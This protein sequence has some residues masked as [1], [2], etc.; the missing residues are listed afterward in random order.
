MSRKT[1]AREVIV[2][3]VRV[4]GELGRVPTQEEYLLN[5]G[6]FSEDTLELAF[7][8]WDMGIRA[9]GLT[10]S[11]VEKQE[12]EEKR[13]PRI[14]LFDLETSGILVR[15]FRLGEQVVGLPQIVEDSY[16]LGFAAKFLGDPKVFYMDQSK[17]EVLS[18]TKAMLRV[19]RNLLLEADV[20][21]T[22]N[23]KNF[24]E[25]VANAV[26]ILNGLDPV[27]KYAHM[28]TLQ[29]SRGRFKF[30]SHKLEYMAKALDVPCKKL[31]NRKFIGMELWNQCHARNPEAWAE[32]KEYCVGDVLALDGVFE[33]LRPW[34]V[35]GVNLN[36]FYSDNVFRCQCSSSEF[37]R[38]GYAYTSA[39]KFQ[40]F[41]CK[42][43]AAWHTAKGAENNL[44]SGAKKS[45]MKTPKA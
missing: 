26:F 42:S 31:M 8:K 1:L 15:I 18:D 32:M 12:P 41:Q 24:D 20:V 11:R 34:G 3:I 40:R 25:K 10:P 16:L 17:A 5:G 29:M 2:D 23:G 22:Q 28:D 38:R 14:L 37:H 9:A 36:A 4:A 19:L 7:S 44:M 43:C 6:V 39:G 13:E 21:I 45:S 33:K 35:G 27:P 30:T